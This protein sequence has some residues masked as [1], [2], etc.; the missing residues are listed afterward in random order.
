M[1]A[2][3]EIVVPGEAPARASLEHWPLVTNVVSDGYSI[4]D[5][6]DTLAVNEEA[7]RRGEPFVT[8]RDVRT[9]TQQPP[10]LQRRRLAQWQ[11]EWRPAIEKNCLA[12][13]TV[14]ESALVRGMIRAIFWVSSPATD[15]EVFSDLGSASLWLGQKLEARGVRLPER[16]RAWQ[17]SG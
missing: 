11:D 6:E 7:L 5:M 17:R 2:A 1:S 10:A 8:I 12:V 15:E 4:S 13:A 16:L 14:T 3:L 9:L